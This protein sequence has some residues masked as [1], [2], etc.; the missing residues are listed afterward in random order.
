MLPKH[1]RN[2]QKANVPIQ[3]RFSECVQTRASERN[4]ML[5]CVQPASQCWIPRASWDQFL[6]PYIADYYRYSFIKFST[7]PFF[8]YALRFVGQGA[9][10]R[11]HLRT[12]DSR[13]EYHGAPQQRQNQRDTCS[14]PRARR[15]V[16]KVLQ[17][18]DRGRVNW[19]ALVRGLSWW[20]ARVWRYPGELPMRGLPGYRCL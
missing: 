5:T 8:F 20:F 16:F 14:L 1:L 7:L 2:N 9:S 13:V 12:R 10:C 15:G 4:R 11:T 17:G 18:R 19:K 3:T 6:Y